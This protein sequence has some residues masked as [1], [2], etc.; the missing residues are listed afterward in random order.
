MMKKT[1][2]FGREGGI[3]TLFSCEKKGVLEDA[4]RLEKI[5]NLLR[6]WL[7]ELS[8]KYSRK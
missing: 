3:Y 6:E 5:K 8:S 2:I 1:E 4:R 7:I